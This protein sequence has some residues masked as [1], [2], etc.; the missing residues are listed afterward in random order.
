M[1]ELSALLN[2][3]KRPHVVTDLAQVAENAIAAQSGVIGVTLKGGVSAAK[4]IDS[5][6]M[7]KIVNRVLPDLLGELQPYWTAYEANSGAD[8]G[9][10]SFGAYLAQNDEK[11]VDSFLSV[12]DRNAEKAPNVLGKVYN[13]LRGKASKIVAPALP[14]FGDAIEKN[15]K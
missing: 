13:T 7:E 10:S 14:E 9:A 5:D 15:M 4:K 6:L 8:S 1:P 3:E 11:V 2:E 12:A